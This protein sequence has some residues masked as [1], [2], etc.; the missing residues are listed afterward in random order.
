MRLTVLGSSGGYPAPG[1]PSSGSLLEHG[2]AK[3]WIDA[4]N[5]TFAE[6]QRLADFTK[7]DALVL[8][9]VHADHC[10]D[11][12]PL[13]VA[14][15][16]GEH[17][18]LRL[19]LYC[20]PGVRETLGKLLGEGGWEDLGEAFEFHTVDAGDTVEISGIRLRFLRMDHPAH[21]LG[22]RAETAGGTLTYSADT[23]TGADLAGFAK[24]SDL[25]LCEATYQEGKMGG[26]VHL[27]ARQ[28]GDIARR[29]GVRELVLT[30]VW[31]TF[32]PRISLAEA[33]DAAGGLPVR[34]ARSGEV[35]DVG[36]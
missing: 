29:A 17:S 12:F 35:F 34:W 27:S 18:G 20:P 1:N 30:H 36:G 4:G 14:L 11:V 13:H 3:L 32:D 19:P 26:P 33:R 16:Y 6:L 28:A 25:L 10:A 8:S 21:T 22:I 7:I 31:P 9:H 5:G 2:G 23:H 24:G 15:R